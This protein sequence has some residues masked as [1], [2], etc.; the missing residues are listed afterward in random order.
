M[1]GIGFK[2]VHCHLT[3]KIQ[4]ASSGDEFMGFVCLIS[5]TEMTEFFFLFEKLN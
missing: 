1:P 3:L 2:F 4:Q 5:G